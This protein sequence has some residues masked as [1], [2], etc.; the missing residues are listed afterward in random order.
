MNILAIDLG[1]FNSMCSAFL[2]PRH[3][4]IGSKQRLRREASDGDP[5]ESR[6]RSGGHG[7]LRAKRLNLRSVSAAQHQEAAGRIVQWR[8]LTL[9][10]RD[11]GGL[12]WAAGLM[13][14]RLCRS[15]IELSV[16]LP[17]STEFAL[18]PVKLDR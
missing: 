14:M 13:W 9:E 1:K 17:R 3:T 18:Q 15:A 8:H 11:P 5:Q 4:N 10:R 7:S 6:D 2:I 16:M 12:G